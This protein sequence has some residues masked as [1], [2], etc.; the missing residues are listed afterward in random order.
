M[1]GRNVTAKDTQGTV[2]QCSRPLGWGGEIGDCVE[3]G[4]GAGLRLDPHYCYSAPRPLTSVGAVPGRRV[5]DHRGSSRVS[6]QGATEDTLTGS[7]SAG[8]TS[9]QSQASLVPLQTPGV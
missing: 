2:H 8:H 1:S 6:R 3:G 9:P 7:S 4:S 5:T